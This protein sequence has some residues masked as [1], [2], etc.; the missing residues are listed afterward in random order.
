[1]GALHAGLYLYITFVLSPAPSAPLGLKIRK[2][3]NF[4]EIETFL[5][6]CLSLADRARLA[7]FL[8]FTAI[9]AVH[10]HGIGDFRNLLC[11]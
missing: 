9:G 7:N 10:E 11:L 3:N 5:V 6:D 8:L 2:F 4:S 1:V